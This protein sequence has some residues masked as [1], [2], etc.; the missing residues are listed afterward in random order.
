MIRGFE[1][2]GEAGVAEAYMVLAAPHD[3]RA[4]KDADSQSSKC[5]LIEDG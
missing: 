2:A 5:Y 4:G 3:N 1:R